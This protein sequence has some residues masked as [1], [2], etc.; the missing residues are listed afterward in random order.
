MTITGIIDHVG[1]PRTFELPSATGGK[2]QMTARGLRNNNPLNI[3]RTKTSSWAGMCDVQ[4]DKSFCQFT[5]M[6]YGWRAAF[7]LLKLYYAQR[8]L[9]TIRQIVN[10][11][12]PPTDGNATEAYITRVCAYSGI[13][14]DAALLYLTDDSMA[15]LKIAM[16][17]FA[18]ECGNVHIDANE[19]IIGYVLA[20]KDE[21]K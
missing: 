13:G 21:V 9:H 17:M 8:K 7:M 10:R 20:I 14:P 6:R 2:K 5:K 16:A 1:Q 3:R 19:F 4:T 15:W 12:A 18:V 11:W